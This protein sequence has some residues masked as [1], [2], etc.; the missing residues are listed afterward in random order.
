MVHR[1]TTRESKR[2]REDRVSTPLQKQ[3]RHK[4]KM[5][6]WRRCVAKLAAP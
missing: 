6:I 3:K 4:N 5:R 2:I 1:G